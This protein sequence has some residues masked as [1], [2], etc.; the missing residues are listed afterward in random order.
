[1]KD[2]LLL[3]NKYI[4]ENFGVTWEVPLVEVY[5][6]EEG[7]SLKTSK[8]CLYFSGCCISSHRSSLLLYLP[9]TLAQTVPD[10]I[11]KRTILYNILNAICWLKRLCMMVELH[12]I[13]IYRRS[14]G[15]FSK[16]MIQ[17]EIAWKIISIFEFFCA[18]EI[19]DSLGGMLKDRSL[20]MAWRGTEEIKKSWVNNITYI[21]T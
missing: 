8:F 7:Y 9:T 11:N 18:S 13:N 3:I 17:N 15:I 5:R 12:S 19:K 1:V 6:V 14:N 21:H 16:K 10:F 20:F 2:I 4:K